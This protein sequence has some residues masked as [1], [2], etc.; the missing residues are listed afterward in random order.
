MRLIDADALLA[1][2]YDADAL[3]M[4][5]VGIIKDAPTI[6]APFTDCNNCKPIKVVHCAECKYYD[7]PFCTKLY[8]DAEQTHHPIYRVIAGDMYCA[9]GEAKNGD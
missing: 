6:E 7:A 1:E 3:T 4:R 9:L 5:G 2:L 8:E